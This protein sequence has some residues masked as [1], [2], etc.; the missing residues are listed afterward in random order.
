MSSPHISSW[1]HILWYLP[2]WNSRKSRAIPHKRRTAQRPSLVLHRLARQEQPLRLLG[3]G[4]ADL[5]PGDPWEIGGKS[6]A[7]PWKS[8]GNLREMTGTNW[9][10]MQKL[11][12][13]DG[14]SIEN[15]DNLGSMSESWK[16][17]WFEQNGLDEI[18]GTYMNV[19]K[20]RSWK[21]WTCYWHVHTQLQNN[22]HLK[23]PQSYHFSEPTYGLHP[24]NSPIK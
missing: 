5:Q 20:T 13:I 14:K 19:F 22:T 16:K 17:T 11:W 23:H 3:A 7:N 24:R 2:K 12:K 21:L 9:T 18:H 1:F 10:P 8:K 15:P 4:L 6:V